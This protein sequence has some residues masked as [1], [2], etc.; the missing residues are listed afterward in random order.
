ME[1][2]RSLA[3]EWLS[4]QRKAMST[5]RDALESFLLI[6]AIEAEIE[7]NPFKFLLKTTPKPSFFDVF[8]VSKR[9]N[10]PNATSIDDAGTRFNNAICDFIDWVIKEKLSAPDD[11]G[12]FIVP[13]EFHNPF[14][15]LS[16]CHSL[17]SE[18]LKM[19]L[20]FR[21]IKILRSMLAE[22]P[23]FRDWKWAQEALKNG[24]SSGDWF[25]IDPKLIKPE[26]PDCVWRERD[27]TRYE[28]TYSK[29]PDRIT[30]VWSPTRAVAVFLKLELPLRTFQVM[31]LDSG[32]ADTWRYENGKFRLNDSPLAQST[33]KCP[34]QKGVFHRSVNEAEAGFYINTNKTADIYKNEK[35]KG[36]VIPWT[37]V[38]ALYWLEKLR[39]WQECYNPISAPMCWSALER[40]HF[41]EMPPHPEVLEERGSACF[42]FRDASAYGADR[43]KPMPK[44]AFN[45]LWYFLLQKLEHHCEETGDKLHDGSR[46][47]FVDPTRKDVTYF[48]P[49]ALR[50][51]LITH[52]VLD[53]GLPI[54][55][56]SKLI[57]GHARIIM[58][59]YY[60][61][62]G[63]SYVNE[64]MA[65]AERKSLASE[66]L[67]QKRFLMDRSY[68]EIS[69]RFAFLSEDAPKACGQQSSAAG[70][71]IEDKGIC[72]VGSG[73]CD[74]GGERYIIR[75]S[76]QAYAPVPGYPQE[77]NCIRCRFF[78]TGPAFLPGLQS[79][80][81]Q[82]SY[83][84]H[85]N[86]ER[87]N[88]L[89]EDITQLENLRAECERNDRLFPKTLELE[90][91]S[92]R[93]EAMAETM[94]RC[95]NDMQACHH[96]IARCIDIA[97]EADREGIQ[98]VAAGKISDIRYALTETQSEL[99]QIEILC[100]N[101]VIYPE[102]DARKTTLRRSQLLDCMLEMNGKPP[103]FYRLT[104]EQQLHTGNAVM[105]LIQARSGSM[106]SAVEFVEGQRQLHELGLLEEAFGIITESAAK[107]PAK[108]IF[109]GGRTQCELPISKG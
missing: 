10:T 95:I 3:A 6:Y 29:L 85:E 99:H 79:R 47:R 91:L 13:H 11:N 58:T 80:F 23:T 24:T 8:V 100:E 40:R 37:N 57:A 63:K 64:V 76:E 54:A 61:K 97:G 72:P 49:H 42:L 44:S 74:V 108:L 59:L 12:Q 84:A 83:E 62:A 43:Q 66:G 55:V 77:R 15:K 1:E 60:T 105:K 93:Y 2:W 21:Y 26:D 101:T 17:P 98:L 92:Q 65:E 82:I 53:L 90:R 19:P 81:N 34:R 71:V 30:E 32:E 14:R 5:K 88:Q 96:L 50:V 39:N 86:A 70:F 78:L 103:V 35:D 94:G 36:Y 87:Y 73:L 75:K 102:I 106:A 33:E 22:G 107:V 48:P 104:P 16:W 109:N 67:S 27:T 46:I 18:T 51:S 89:G 31:M 7:R 38:A 68:E 4:Q 69:R 28:Q 45:R 9:R 52:Y 25:M 56:V 41:G 20:P